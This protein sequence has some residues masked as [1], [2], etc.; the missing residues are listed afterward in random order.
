MAILATGE[1][2]TRLSECMLRFSERIL[3]RD[4]EPTMLTLIHRECNSPAVEVDSAAAERLTIALPEFPFTCFT[5][6][7]E[8]DDESEVRF[9]EEIR[10]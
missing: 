1:R 3:S 9:S 6:L 5:C 7:E 4:E 8:I 10:M 2:T